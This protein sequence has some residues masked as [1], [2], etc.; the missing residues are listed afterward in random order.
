MK[1]KRV[2]I[3]RMGECVFTEKNV[4]I[5]TLDGPKK[6]TDIC[7]NIGSENVYIRDARIERI[8]M[9]QLRFF[10]YLDKIGLVTLVVWFN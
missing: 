7:I 4:K 5:H 3:L 2:T 10:G 8:L 6:T 9:D 1:A